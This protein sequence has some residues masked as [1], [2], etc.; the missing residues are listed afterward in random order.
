MPI[1]SMSQKSPPAIANIWRFWRN[2]Q[3][4]RST[5]TANASRKNPMESGLVAVRV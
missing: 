1:T 2:Q 3:T 5:G 4:V